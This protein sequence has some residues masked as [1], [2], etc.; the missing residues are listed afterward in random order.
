SGGPTARGLADRLKRQCAPRRLPVVAIGDPG[1]AI[2]ADGFDLA[3]AAP[4]HPAQAVMRLESLVR[5]AVAEEEF[6][7]RA[8]TFAERGQILEAA[9]HDGSR[10]RILA[11]GEP[12][13]QF[14]ALSNA[15][16]QAGAEVVGAFTAYT[17]FDYLHERPF[18]AVVLWA[19]DNR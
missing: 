3:L 8:Q 17:A 7:L 6:E 15:L 9:E 1:P 4:L 14:L 10:F 11:V 16:A 5:M 2:A 18:D 19:G 13:P 12:A